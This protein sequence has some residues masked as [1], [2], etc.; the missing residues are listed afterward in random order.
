MTPTLAQEGTRTSEGHIGDTD[1][2]EAFGACA[3]VTDMLSRVGD[4]WS[5]QVVMKLGEQPRRF[6]ELRRAVD[7]IS[8]RMLTRTLR[9]L[10]RDGL[11]SRTVTPTVPPRVD[12]ALTGMGHSLAEPVRRLSHWVLENRMEIEAARAEYDRQD[13]D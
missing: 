12:Y 1:L 10:E 5:M 8:Q 6:N 7:G 9:N 2:I 4:K 11:I 13:A 3:A